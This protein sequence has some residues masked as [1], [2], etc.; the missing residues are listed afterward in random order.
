MHV[1]VVVVSFFS[2]KRKNIFSYSR[3]R[4]H[5]L[6]STWIIVGGILKS[7][8]VTRQMPAPFAQDFVNI[9]TALTYCHERM[10]C[11][12]S[13]LDTLLHP[14]EA[15]TTGVLTLKTV[16]DAN[17]QSHVYAWCMGSLGEISWAGCSKYKHVIWSYCMFVSETRSCLYRW[18]LIGK[19]E[20]KRYFCICLPLNL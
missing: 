20:T 14:S 1:F 10:L 17:K 6:F 7:K 18:L 4:V 11:S 8:L 16:R 19:V 13:F 5:S 3:Y 15:E 12:A 2:H 9:N